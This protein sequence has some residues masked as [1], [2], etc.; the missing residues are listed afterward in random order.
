MQTDRR[1]VGVF[2]RELGA[3]VRQHRLLAGVSQEDLAGRVGV[4]FQQVQKYEKGVNRMSA[5]RFFDIADKLGVA[6][7]VLAGGAIRA[8]TKATRGKAQRG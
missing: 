1:A 2:D 4:T 6:P 3:A 5:A 7:M 8:R